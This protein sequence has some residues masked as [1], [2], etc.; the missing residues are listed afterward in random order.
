MFRAL[1]KR[2]I[3]RQCR[4]LLEFIEPKWTLDTVVGH[5][6]AKARLREDAALLKRG[7]LDSL[8]MGYLL[9]GP[10]GTGKSFLAQCVS[11]EIGVPCVML[12]NF[13]SKYVGETEGNLERVLSVL[14]AMG[15]VV[16]VVDEADAALGSRE[17]EGDSGTSS[18]VFA[19]IAAQMGDTRY[20]G[21]IIWMLLTARPDLLPIDLKRQGRAEVHIPLFYPTDESRDPADVR[22]PGEEARVAA[23][24]RGRAADS[25]ARA[26][27]GRRHRGHGRPRAGGRR[28]SPG[29]DHVTREALAEVVA[30]VH[31]VD[32]GARARAAGDGG[33]PRVH[34]PA[35]PAAGD[36]AEDRRPPADARALQERLTALKQIV[37]DL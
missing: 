19:M 24:A 27:V 9:C 16:V 13:R 5:E 18:R 20:R 2:L 33:D 8:P 37:K 32:A 31:A 26:S 14:R 23:G 10:V 28:C 11:G 29:A 22:D 17:Q 25:A 12:K 7:A 30:A 21:R 15:P 36:P 6:A 4:G 34:R 35:V 3:E 1:K